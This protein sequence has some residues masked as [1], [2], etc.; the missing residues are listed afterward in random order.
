MKKALTET[1]SN[2]KRL[3]KDE[4]LSFIVLVAK[5]II[6]KVIKVVSKTKGEFIWSKPRVKLSCHAD[7]HS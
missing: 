6:A 3:I 5:S 2:N 7:I 1:E 4:I